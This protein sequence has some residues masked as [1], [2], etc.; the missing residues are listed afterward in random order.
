MKKFFIKIILFLLIS[1]PL[2]VNAVVDSNLYVKD[3]KSI[4]IVDK[5]SIFDDKLSIIAKGDS[6]MDDLM[7]KDE[8]AK[9]DKKISKLIKKY[10]KWVMFLTP[11]GLIVLM[12][13][14]FAKAMS[15]ED[16]DAVKKSSSNAIKRVIAAVILLALPWVIKVVFTWFGIEQFLCF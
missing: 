10:W 14:D 8:L 7:P 3:A 13:V 6:N 15:S 5:L 2:K 1:Y 12:T 11:L 4:S 16:A 9:C